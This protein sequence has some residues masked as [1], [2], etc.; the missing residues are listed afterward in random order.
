M[1][2]TNFCSIDWKCIVAYSLKLVIKPIS[3]GILPISSFSN[4]DNDSAVEE[5]IKQEII[6]L[7]KHYSAPSLVSYQQTGIN[8]ANLPNA[9]ME[10]NSDGIDPESLFVDRLNSAWK[11]RMWEGQY[12]LRRQ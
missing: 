2:R 3:D 7:N 11:M 12:Y 8:R 1:I 4:K 10:P 5:C 6:S 9:V